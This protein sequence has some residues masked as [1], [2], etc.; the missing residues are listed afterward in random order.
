[1]IWYKAYMR[2]ALL[3]ARCRRI[4]ASLGGQNLMACLIVLAIL[5]NAFQIKTLPAPERYAPFPSYPGAKISEVVSSSEYVR[6]KYE[7]F[8]ELGERY[9][10]STIIMSQTSQLGTY[11]QASLLSYGRAAHIAL[12]SYDEEESLSGLDYDRLVVARGKGGPKG[13][14]FAIA[15]GL[16]PTTFLVLRRQGTTILLDLSLP[17]RARSTQDD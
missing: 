16:N 8:F 9:P 1:M 2:G 7:V 11:F 17:L 14:P 15:A 3:F 12:G 4:I 5:I 13:P 10:G 6:S